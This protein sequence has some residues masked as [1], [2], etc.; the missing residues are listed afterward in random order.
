MIWLLCLCFSGFMTVG[1]ILSY[2]LEQKVECLVIAGVFIILDIICMIKY[3][4]AKTGKTAAKKRA[5]KEAKLESR[6]LEKRTIYVKHQTG[7][8]LA[9]GSPC[10]I[11]REEQY[12]CFE[13]SGIRYELSKDKVTD[14]AVKTDVEIQKQ[15]VSSAGGSLAGGMLFGPLGAI[16]AGRTKVKKNRAVTNYL[17]FTYLADEGISYISFELTGQAQQKKI[18]DWKKEI[19]GNENRGESIQL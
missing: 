13:G 10:K 9:Q 7:L 19:A 4:N 14:I 17:I 3:R 6:E 5:R 11:M 1:G 2:V 8:P 15:Y 18:N 16:V 12:F